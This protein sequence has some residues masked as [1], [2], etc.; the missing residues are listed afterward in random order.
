MTTTTTETTFHHYSCTQ[1]EPLNFRQGKHE[2][3][4]TCPSC[5]RSAPAAVLLD[6][7]LYVPA[8]E[9]SRP[10][11]VAAIPPVPATPHRGGWPTHRAKARR[12]AARARYTP[13]K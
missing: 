7:S 1:E 13:T 9:P 11:E 8:A 12:S 2:P 5:G 10:R 6:P 3:M 4:V